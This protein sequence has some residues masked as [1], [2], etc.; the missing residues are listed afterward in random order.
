MDIEH[1]ESVA[2]AVGGAR[3]SGPPRV[4]EG[5]HVHLG[6]PSGWQVGV[7]YVLVNDGGQIYFTLAP[8]QTWQHSRPTD[9]V[10]AQYNGSAFALTN[11]SAR[12][13]NAGE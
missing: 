13:A 11:T 7:W 1:A 4:E 9:D 3:S 12:G 6:D 2:G 8:N 5:E 10:Y